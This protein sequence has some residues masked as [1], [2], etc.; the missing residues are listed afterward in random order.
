MNFAP[1]LRLKECAR[2]AL[3]H[4]TWWFASRAQFI[5]QPLFSWTDRTMMMEIETGGL[6]GVS[7]FLR[8]H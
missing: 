4:K 2:K 3:Q 5:F 7:A 8:S 1:M 6:S